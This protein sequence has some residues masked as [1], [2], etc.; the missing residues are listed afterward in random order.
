[1]FK[2]SVITDELSQDLEVAASFAKRFNL[3]G[4]EIRSIWGR[5]P[6]NLLERADEIK[7]ILSKHGLKVSAIASPLFKADIDNE[8]EYKEHIDILKKCVELA[9]KL[10]AEIIRG[11]TFWRKGKL[12]DRINQIVDK[13]QKP[14]EIIENEDL[15]LGVENEP[16]TFTGN[17]RELATFLSRIESKNIKAIWDPGNDIFDPS[18]EIPY[19]DG[20]RY[21]RGRIV[22]VH[23]KDGVRKGRGGKPEW[24]PIGEGEVAYREQLKALKEDGYEGYISLET[25]WR[26]RRGLSEEKIMRPGGE[27]FSRDAMEASEICMRNL[28]QILGSLYPS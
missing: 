14:L 8:R 21:L 20:Y 7:R 9:R 26:P 11:F 2:L 16:S 10:D 13:Y 25:H 18:G 3:D 28:L 24:T 1:M 6:Q 4:V 19:P 17:G 27:E 22:H 23:V 5:S 12:Q 15:I